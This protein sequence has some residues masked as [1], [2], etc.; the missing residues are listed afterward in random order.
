MTQSAFL[1]N[2]TLDR[3]ISLNHL[4]LSTYLVD[5]KFDEKRNAERQQI[6]AISFVTAIY[7]IQI[8]HLYFFPGKEEALEKITSEGYNRL[9]FSFQSE[10]LRTTR[11]LNSQA[12]MKYVLVF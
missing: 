1:L 11:E 4:V 7:L 5:Q 9:N 6:N 10:T 8:L 3:N 12:D 2:P